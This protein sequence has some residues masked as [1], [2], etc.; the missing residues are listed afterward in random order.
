MKLYRIYL[1]QAPIYC[2]DVNLAATF[3]AF[4]RNDYEEVEVVADDF[5]EGCEHLISMT[6]GKHRLFLRGIKEAE[7]F[8]SVSKYNID[9]YF[10]TTIR[11][12]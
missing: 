5:Q 8:E 6:C 9:D 3:A 10:H 7:L 2:T 1:H 11:E 12:I 4:S